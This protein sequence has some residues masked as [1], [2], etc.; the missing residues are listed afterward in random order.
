LAWSSEPAL[1]IAL[2]P[3]GGDAS[4]GSIGILL[5]AL[6]TP[7]PPDRFSESSTTVQ[8]LVLRP[9]RD[10]DVDAVVTAF[11]IPDI[12]YFHFLSAG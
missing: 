10:A 6:Q 1:L 7:E 12:H 11:S 9:F 5:T 8:R 2:L 4:K 3:P